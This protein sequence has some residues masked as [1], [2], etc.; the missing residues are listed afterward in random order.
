[1]GVV[2]DVPFAFLG[3]GEVRSREESDFLPALLLVVVLVVFFVA[4]GAMVV[5]L[6]WVVLVL[7]VLRF[8]S[9]E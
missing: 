3:G 9:D 7:L 1:L 2:V 8:E 4:V 6:L 5:L